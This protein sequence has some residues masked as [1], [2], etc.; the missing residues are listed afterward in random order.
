MG[1]NKHDL[2][3]WLGVLLILL[4]VA[5]FLLLTNCQADFF[6]NISPTL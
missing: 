5:A 4:V 3:D 6:R 2:G 1:K